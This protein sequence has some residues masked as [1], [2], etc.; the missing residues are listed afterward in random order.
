MEMDNRCECSLRRLDEAPEQTP[1]QEKSTSGAAMSALQNAGFSYEGADF[2]NTRPTVF[3][4]AY[5]AGATPA[6]CSIISLAVPLAEV[7]ML[8]GAQ[9]RVGLW[10]I[11]QEG[12]LLLLFHVHIFV[13]SIFLDFIKFVM[14]INDLMSR[15][16]AFRE[17]RRAWHASCHQWKRECLPVR[18]ANTRKH[19]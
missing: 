17:G 9:C 14:K 4:V 16:R 3:A 19:V 12:R 6:C 1:C 8:M 18:F 10:V 2:S 7:A 13:R 5:S 11:Q 15:S